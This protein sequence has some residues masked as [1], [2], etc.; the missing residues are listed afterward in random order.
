MSNTSTT[1]DNPLNGFLADT[2]WFALTRRLPDEAFAALVEK[3]VKQG[4]TAVQLV[5]GIPPEVGPEHESASSP[6]GFPWTLTGEF[7]EA[8]LA[9][10]RQRIGYL[11]AHGLRVIVYGAWGHQIEWLGREQMTGWW[12]KI[13]ATVDDLDV[14]Y[15]LTGESNIWL[16]GE[17]QHL[18]PDKTTTGYSVN[19]LKQLVG[20]LPYRVQGWLIEWRRKTQR[21]Y[22][23]QKLNQRRQLWSQVLE[24]IITETNHPFIVHTLPHE[25]SSEVVTRPELLAAVTTQ[26]GHSETT[27]HLLWQRPLAHQGRPFIN[28]EPWYE[29]ING[30]FGPADQLFAY[31]VS[32]LAGAQSYCYG[33]HGIWNVGD[34]RFLA[35]WG[36]QTFADAAALDTP[37]LLGLSHQRFLEARRENGRPFTEVHHN[38]LITIGQTWDDGLIQ[39]FPDVAQAKTVPQGQIWLPRRGCWTEALPSSGQVVVFKTS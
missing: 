3:R 15:C 18:L 5:V 33:A 21:P 20:H 28:L 31:W 6:V 8:Y 9:F 16:W 37:R 38:Q 19:R 12:R 13:I 34:G 4:F 22:L 35:H 26:T 1:P 32:M 14:V 10:A 23:E 2:W 29:G 27:R 11:N 25:V 17:A 39:F 30:Q 7:N 36:G 24:G